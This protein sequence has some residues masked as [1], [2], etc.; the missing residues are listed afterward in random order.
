MKDQFF[1]Y[2]SNFS[3]M[4]ITASKSPENDSPLTNDKL[5]I[6]RLKS[7]KPFFR[8]FLFSNHYIR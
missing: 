2:L 7:L 1:E 8:L 4:G 6:E 3:L 5:A